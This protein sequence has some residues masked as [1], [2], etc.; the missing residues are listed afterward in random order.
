MLTLSIATNV[1]G[2]AAGYDSS[3]VRVP[4]AWYI[5][6][7][8]KKALRVRAVGRVLREVS[9]TQAAALGEVLHHADWTITA[10]PDQVRTLGLAH[11]CPA[12]HA[13][14]DQA[15]TYL[16]ENPEGEVAVG[17]LWWAAQ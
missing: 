10:D 15:L 13:G 1:R 16:R 14:V 12:C 3:I 7:E 11:G 4:A 17:Q 5:G 2:E 8:G 6:V 9:E